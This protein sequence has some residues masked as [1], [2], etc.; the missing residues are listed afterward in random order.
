MLCK[1]NDDV[2]YYVLFIACIA[3]W[4]KVSRHNLAVALMQRALREGNSRAFRKRRSESVG[5]WCNEKGIQSAYLQYDSDFSKCK[6][7]LFAW[8]HAS[9]ML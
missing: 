8:Y 1:Q 7:N 6:Q 9:S 5:D 4:E 3:V 2:I